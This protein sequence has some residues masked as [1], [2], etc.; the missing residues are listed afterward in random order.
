MKLVAYLPRHDALRETLRRLAEGLSV[1]FISCDDEE[2]FRKAAAG[3]APRR[4]H[5]RAGEPLLLV[6]EESELTSISG[7]YGDVPLAVFV[8]TAVPELLGALPQG[9]HARHFLALRNGEPDEDELAA[10]LSR[11]VR[12]RLSPSQGP[13]D[14]LL[15]YGA[16]SA[17]VG[18]AQEQRVTSLEE[19]ALAL[20]RVRDAVLNDA[21]SQAH[22]VRA[23]EYARKATELVDELILNAVFGANPRMRG[24]QR[25][26]PFVLPDNE[27]VVV[28]WRRDDQLLGVSVSDPFGALRFPTLLSHLDAAA[29]QGDVALKA[30]AGLGLRMAFDRSHALFVEVDEGARTEIVAFLRLEKTFREFEKRARSLH[31]F[32]GEG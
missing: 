26:H 32:G 22:D 20:A 7:R 19:K 13:H 28:R 25:G 15:A 24:M 8:K 23:S 12:R 21:T 6:T 1:T 3:N 4:G 5:A 11:L 2:A 9:A 14:W 16:F 17:Q 18:T 27:A 10:L 29:L 30:S 31:F